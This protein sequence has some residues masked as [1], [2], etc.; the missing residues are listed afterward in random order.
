M[1]SFV[2]QCS[3]THTLDL[4]E[5]WLLMNIQAQVLSS[6]LTLVAFVFLTD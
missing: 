1:D 5:L 2:Q 6:V 3:H 4:W